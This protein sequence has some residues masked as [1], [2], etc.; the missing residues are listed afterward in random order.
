MTSLTIG[1][2]DNPGLEFLRAHEKSYAYHSKL[3]FDHIQV[4]EGNVDQLEDLNKLLQAI[5]MD[6]QDLKDG[7]T[8]DYNKRSD[9]K[10]LV[11][12]V[13]KFAPGL[14]ADEQGKKRNEPPEK[15]GLVFS[16]KGAEA[17]KENIEHQTK[18][19]L[20]TMSS[21]KILVEEL[22]QK[23]NITTELITDVIKD[24]KELLKA[25]SRNSSGR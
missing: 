25:I 20:M 21:D 16:K 3:I 8:I 1:P 11:E 18:S 2:S 4:N 7:E 23:R 15:P 13:F 12:N 6:L 22:F 24:L 19:I 10:E 5:N 9:R 17:L 14:F